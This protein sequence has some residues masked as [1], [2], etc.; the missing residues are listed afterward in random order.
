[1]TFLK[2]L[3]TF[4]GYNRKGIRLYSQ[5]GQDLWVYAETHPPRTNGFF[6][7]I[8]AHDGVHISNTRMLEESLGWKGICIEANP[9][10]FDS[11]KVNRTA[12]CVQACLDHTEHEVEFVHADIH[13]GIIGKN[14]DN[15]S[16]SHSDGPITKLKTKTLNQVLIDAKAP[17]IIH[18]LSIDVEGAEERILRDF[19]FDKYEIHALTVER[20]NAELRKLLADKGFTLV[21][22]IPELDCFYIHQSKLK[23][24]RRAIL[25]YYKN[26]I[27]VY[28]EDSEL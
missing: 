22:E 13:G 7:D 17:R 10:L 26:R 2:N 1:M 9:K 23:K 11:L 24:N 27:S 3:T 12:T 20:P 19:A 18:Y 21:K 5:A 16:D 14:L 8:G 6:V 28:Q 15:S 25:N 4:L